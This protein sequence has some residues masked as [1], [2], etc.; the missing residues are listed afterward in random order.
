[1]GAATSRC[2]PPST[3]LDEKAR[4]SVV[5]RAAEGQQN[6]GARHSL[7]TAARRQC[8]RGDAERHN[9]HLNGAAIKENSA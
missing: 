9:E 6:E 5:M 4:R 7:I 8:V 1:L 3:Q 2:P